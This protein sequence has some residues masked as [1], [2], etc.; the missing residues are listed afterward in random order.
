MVLLSM[1]VSRTGSGD[2]LL[3]ILFRKLNGCHGQTS[4]FS[5]EC[6]SQQTKEKMIN[7]A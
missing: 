4:L 2:L 5:S 6:F 7:F 3:E 1:I